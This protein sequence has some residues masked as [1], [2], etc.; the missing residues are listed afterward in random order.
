MTRVIAIFLNFLSMTYDTK[1]ET[2]LAEP[3]FMALGTIRKDG[4]PHMTMVWYAYEQEG[5]FRV[6]VTTQRV[7]YRNVSQDPRVSF[8]IFDEKN[9]YRYFQATGRV[10]DIAKD[11]S[12]EFIDSLAKRYMGKDRYPYDPERRENR[13]ILTITPERFSTIGFD[14]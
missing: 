3:H 13:V 4:T 9:P 5:V 6:S 12:F 2:F 1:I 10:T 11:A 8:M 7:K 14:R